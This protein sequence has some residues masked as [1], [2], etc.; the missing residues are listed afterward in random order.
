[1]NEASASGTTPTPSGASIAPGARIG[2]YDVVHRIACGGMAEIY[3]ARA[4][5]LYGFEKHVVLKRI[6]PQYAAHMEFVRM[7]LKEARLA[8]TLDHANIA[9]VYDIDESGGSTFFTMEY[10]HGEDVRQIVRKLAQLGRELP[11]EHALHIV[12]GAAAGLHFAHDKR[13]PDGRSLGIVHRDISPANIVVTYEG[14]VKVVDFGV[15]KL[16][17]DPELSQRYAL[18][19]KLAYM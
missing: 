11:L 14:G 12:T 5:G 13:G 10:L 8:A 16:A 17:N 18:K 6:L 4:N 9:H 7:F 19:G 2:K 1:M 15:A 3:L